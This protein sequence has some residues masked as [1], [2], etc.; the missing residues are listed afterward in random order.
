MAASI[1]NR[2]GSMGAVVQGDDVE[3]KAGMCYVNT[4]T[5]ARAASSAA[6]RGKR[7]LD[8]AAA[9]AGDE[10]IHSALRQGGTC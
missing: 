8:V 7:T 10:C 1:S 6:T 4:R 5:V 9:G 2:V 3:L